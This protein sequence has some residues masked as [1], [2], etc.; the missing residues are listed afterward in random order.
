MVPV[1]KGCPKFLAAGLLATGLSLADGATGHALTLTGTIRDFSDSHPDFEYKT[2]TERDLVEAMLGAD[3]KPVFNTS[4]RQPSKTI[5]SKDTFN[6]WYNDVPGVNMSASITF[7]LSEIRPGIFDYSNRAYFPIDNQLLGNEGR[8]HNFHFTTEINTLFTY[9]ASRDDYFDFKGDDDV[10]VFVNNKLAIDLGG[11]HGAQ[12]QKLKFTDLATGFGLID[13]QDYTLD[14]FQAERHTTQSTFQFETSLLL[15]QPDTAV[16]L[17]L[18]GVALAP[19]L[20]F[21][22]ARSRY[23]KLFSQHLTYRPQLQSLGP[24]RLPAGVEI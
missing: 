4:R 12:Q 24:G 5:N 19:L 23:K 10:W 8:K 22:K 21:S 6:Q 3:R 20:L 15:R 11:V 9:D 14:I 1:L 7:T 13:G 17:P 18:T 16:P 2:G